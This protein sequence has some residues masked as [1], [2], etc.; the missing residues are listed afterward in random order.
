LKTRETRTLRINGLMTPQVAEV[1]GNNSAPNA[2]E[3]KVLAQKVR[4][5]S[6]AT[7]IL[8][9]D[10]PAG[11]HLNPAAPQRYSVTVDNAKVIAVA[12]NNAQRSDKKLTLPIR[13]PIQALEMG[14][15]KVRAQAT[16]IYCRDDNTGTCRIK[17]LVWNVPVEV[18]N[19]A[20]ATTELKLNAKL[21]LD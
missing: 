10:L 2:E 4:A 18:V 6:E 20:A 13:V 16:L 17:T 7:L 9:V 15:A 3:Q 14:A 5:R 19:D 8:N 21:S 11:H 12:E 1:S